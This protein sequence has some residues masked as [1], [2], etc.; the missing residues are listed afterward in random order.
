MIRHAA[1]LAVLL[2]IALPGMADAQPAARDAAKG[3]AE[4]LALRCEGPFAK[5]TTHARLVQAFGAANVTVKDVADAAGI[6]TKATVVFDEDPTRRVV[7]YWNDARTRAR[8]SRIVV[9]APSTWVGPGGIHNGL[10]L[11]EVERLNG[12]GFTMIGFGGVGGG[13]VSGLRGSLA[14]L[15]GGCAL[16]LRFSPGISD[17]LPARYASVTGNRVVSSSSFVLR[18]TRPQVSAWSLSYP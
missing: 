10:P 4:P 3:A 13:T 5:E 8:P 7:F 1:C 6:L 12:G 2:A 17:P 16:S 14:D 18:R 15:A 9:E 11:K